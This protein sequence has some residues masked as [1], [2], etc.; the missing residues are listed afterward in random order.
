MKTI[1]IDLSIAK[2]QKIILESDLEIEFLDQPDQTRGSILIEQDEV[3][4]R[5]ISFKNKIIWAS[6]LTVY[7]ENDL[8]ENNTYT[9]ESYPIVLT[10][11]PF[12]RDVINFT[13][14]KGQLYA[15]Y[16]LDFY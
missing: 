12:G 15:S 8:E 9:V 2:V 4:D 16:Y 5:R 6:T 14:I 7:S 13:F 10:N 3:G 1:T 11:K